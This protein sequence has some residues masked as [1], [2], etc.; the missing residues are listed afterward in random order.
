MNEKELQQAFAQ[1]LAQ[2]SGAKN[3]QELE[4]FVKQL[5]KEGLQKEYQK[6]VQLMQKQKAQKAAH[7]A[8]LAY[9][10]KLNGFSCPEGER[11]EYFQKGGKFCKR[12]V[13]AKQ[14]RMEAE[15][16][17]KKA[18]TGT[19]FIQDFKNQIES[20]KCGKKVKK[21]DDGV[22]LRKQ[23]SI[24]PRSIQPYAMQ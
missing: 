21:A 6:F 12:C 23:D 10:S 7:G 11:L 14:E 4:Q 3:Q 5:G 2:I 1:Y 13:K 19:K 20:A 22:K 8:K 9:I 17:T 18:K 16:Q 24:T 15:Q